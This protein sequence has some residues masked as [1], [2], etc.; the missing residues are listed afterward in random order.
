MWGD[1]ENERQKTCVSPR[2]LGIYARRGSN[3][4]HPTTSMKDSI[5]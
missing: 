5:R 2:Q 3:P 1:Q 4:L